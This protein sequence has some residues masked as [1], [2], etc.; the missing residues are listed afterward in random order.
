MFTVD[1]T[2]A[3]LNEI[4]KEVEDGGNFKMKAILY[5]DGH[6]PPK[7]VDHIDGDGL[8]NRRIN[9]R[10]VSRQENLKNK[11]IYSN[12]TSGTVGVKWYEPTQ[13]WQ[14]QIDVDGKRIHS[15]YFTNKYDAIIR[16]E[17]LEIEYEYHK[18]H[19]RK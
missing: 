2:I 3:R 8:N 19:G 4:K 11:P 6:F 15:G 14:V 18:N 16:R 17:E 9:L 10:E 12:N 5:S 7:E 13:K 1:K